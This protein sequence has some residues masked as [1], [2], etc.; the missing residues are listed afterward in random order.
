MENR[1]RLIF[2]L[3]FRLAVADFNFSL[4]SLAVLRL[5][6]PPLKTKLDTQ[7]H[8]EQNDLKINRKGAEG[9]KE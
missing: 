6:N 1:D 5:T 4:P 9:K 8:A 2:R 7:N 3:V